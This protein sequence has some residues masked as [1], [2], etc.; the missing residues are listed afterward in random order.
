M[1]KLLIA[2]E[3]LTYK[4]YRNQVTFPLCLLTFSFAD[5]SMLIKNNIIVHELIL[6]VI[7][8]QQTFC[9]S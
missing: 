7:I 2:L 8:L 5:I 9:T 3:A 1:G 6:V 4:T